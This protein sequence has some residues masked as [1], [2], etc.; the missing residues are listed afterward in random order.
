[1][2][3]PLTPYVP[4]Y[5]TVHLGTPES[6]A[7]NVIVSFPD[8]IKNVA[9]SEIY[10]TWSEAAIYANIYA[11][12]SYALNRIYTEYYRS[13]GYDFNITS[14]TAYDQ[15]FI[16]GRNIYENIDRIVDDIFTS[17][18]RR[19]GNV[20][21]L[22]AK[23]CNGTTVT[24]EGL[25]QWGSEQLAKDGYSAI[26]ILK[27]YYGDDIEIVNNAPIAG[28]IS[29]YPGRAYRRGDRG[30]SV[31]IIQ[32]YLNA[33]SDDYPLIPKINP[34]DG[35]FGEETENAVRTFQ[36]IFNLTPDGIVGKATWNKLT[37][38]YVSIRRLAE[39][40]SEGQSYSGVNLDF[41]D[42]LTIG[43]VGPAVS[44]FQYFL[45]IISNFDQRVPAPQ[46]TGEYDQNT[47]RSVIA[48]QR[49]YGL[50]P[51]GILNTETKN[52][53]YD[54]YTAIIT[55]VL[56][57]AFDNTNSVSPTQFPGNN[58]SSDNSDSQ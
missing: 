47:E 50:E 34:V 42:N 4:D 3:I 30:G 21:P 18:I 51:T 37:L 45:L 35:I 28:I 36:E 15:K 13:R 57:G 14:S 43:S 52:K 5:I 44:S 39:L 56:S 55:V 24:C 41:P 22:A 12:I 9:S 31:T 6:D 11:Q 17:Y 29:L 25:S 1:M 38:L 40:S 20:E 48:F 2:P 8:Y 58:L 33:I 32:Q 16:Y 53:I 46:V 26:D 7:E 23:Y 49:A 27:F 10:P 19:V 54:T